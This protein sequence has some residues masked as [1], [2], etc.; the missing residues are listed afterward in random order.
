MNNAFK[1]LKIASA[2]SLVLAIAACSD[3]K[4]TKQY[5]EEAKQSIA[6]SNYSKAIVEL[7]NAVRQSPDN[8][9]LRY[10]LGDAYLK[11][12]YFLNAEKELERALSLKFDFTLIAPKLTITKSKLNK[13][14][15]VY[16]LVNDAEKLAE[17]VYAQMLTYAGMS[18]FSED[19]K[20]LGQD[21]LSQA[22]AIKGEQSLAKAYLEGALKNTDNALA[23]ILELLK[24]EPSNSE[25][26]LF[27][28]HLYFDLKN[29]ES[30]SDAFESYLALV[31]HDY[32]VMF[33]NVNS[34]IFAEKLDKADEK[35]NKLLSKI[36]DSPLA[37]Q[38]KAQIEYSRKNFTE[39]KVYAEKS[40]NLNNNS[41]VAKMIIGA[42]SYYLDD[43]EQAYNNLILVERYLPETHPLSRMLLVIK[44]RLGYVKQAAKSLDDSTELSKE[45][46]EMLRL[47]SQ[48]L[49]AA[50]DFETAKRL[51][52]K[53]EKLSPDDA[54]I[55][56][57]K[58]YLLLSQGNVLGTTWLEKALEQDPSLTSVELALAIEYMKKGQDKRAVALAKEWVNSENSKVSGYLLQGIIETKQNKTETAKASFKNILVIEPQNITALYNLAVLAST[59]DKHSEAIGYYQQVLSI[60]PD[61]QQALQQLT[62]LQLNNDNVADTI[63]FLS[64]LNKDNPES[65]N[66]II[67]LARNLK[68][69]NELVKSITLL[70][71]IQNKTNLPESYWVMLA[72]SYIQNNQ[73]ELAGKIIAKA[74]NDLPSDYFL[75]LRSIGLL[76]I[77]KKYP[78]ALKATKSALKKFPNNNRLLILLAYHELKNNNPA[79]SRAV[80]LRLNDKKVKHH[81]MDS[82]AGHIA[83]KEKRYKDAIESFNTAFELNPSDEYA[84]N[85]ARALAFDKQQLE[86]EQLLELHL[87]DKQNPMLRAILAELYQAKDYLKAIKQYKIILINQPENTVVLNN[88]AW[89]HFLHKEFTQAL[90]VIE[91]AYKI[92]PEAL[93]VLESYGVILAANNQNELAI[94]IIE[95]AIESGSTDEE[96]IN[97]LADLKK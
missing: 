87:H 53:A 78:E 41:V 75:R 64:G 43:I 1:K 96:A 67:A 56:A 95:Q 5:L 70:E 11:Q 97:T 33:L 15:D 20:E 80:L 44:L 92:A 79:E 55:S 24:N 81:I 17:D 57:Q 51:I 58:G 72:D 3:N 34:L 86:A 85:L 91:K 18:A 14:K 66:V 50:G 16:Q 13:A 69:N 52:D 36:K 45:D 6:A 26:M 40:L 9:E 71:S 31:P 29:Y 59:E 22:I 73:L 39:A 54:E 27:S 68:V 47:S 28:G 32:P 90:S 49:M 83:L 94:N 38:Y 60:N 42:S 62:Q 8:A 82:V 4:T 2:I 89:L 48:E 12:G 23:I 77:E 88:I 25:L 84:L 93:Y 30:A 46:T 61:Y 19:E 21:Y 76:E 65:I 37:N 7:K 74:S 35:V 63:M 10:L